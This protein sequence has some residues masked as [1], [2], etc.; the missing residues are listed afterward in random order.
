MH[1]K[2]MV[3][4]YFLVCLLSAFI[5]GSHGYPECWPNGGVQQQNQLMSNLEKSDFFPK[6]FTAAGKVCCTVPPFSVSCVSAPD[7]HSI[8]LSAS[9]DASASD[10][11]SRSL[12][13]RGLDATNP[14]D[15]VLTTTNP[16]KMVDEYLGQYWFHGDFTAKFFPTGN[17][18]VEVD[19]LRMVFGLGTHCKVRQILANTGPRVFFPPSSCTSKWPLNGSSSF[20]EIC[21]MVS[22]NGDGNGGPAAWVAAKHGD[23]L[24]Q[25][26]LLY[27][28]NPQTE[29]SVA[30]FSIPLCESPVAPGTYALQATF[31]L[32]IDPMTNKHEVI[33]ARGSFGVGGPY[34]AYT[35]PRDSII[36]TF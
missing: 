1:S 13:L 6:K 27:E 21:A 20:W 3:S 32:Q 30:D 23:R 2:K 36:L 4:L 31:A 7:D 26:G 25:M 22:A 14:F 35:M 8:H 18:V 29:L 16:V 5:C 17:T 24:Y 34:P 33:L 15:F 19:M 9:V 28:S 12:K 11:S 10:A